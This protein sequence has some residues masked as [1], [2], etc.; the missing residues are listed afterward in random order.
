MKHI[1][2]TGGSGGVGSKISI[3]LL[4]K[5]Y[6]ISIVGRNQKNY[7]KLIKD[8]KNTSNIQFLK[9]DI[10]KYNEV[11]DLF[12]LLF[13]VKYPLYGLINVAGVQL[14]IGNFY[15]NDINQWKKN[16]SINLLGTV[17]MCYEFINQESQLPIQRKI[18]N[19][20]GGGATFPRPNFSAYSVSKIGIVKFTEILAKELENIDINVI[21]PGALNTKMLDE[22]IDAGENAGEEY[23]ESLKRKITGGNSFEKTIDLCDFLLSSRSNKISGKLI[24]AIWDNFNNNE[25]I[26]RLKKD[27]NFCTLRRI[28]SKNFE[29]IV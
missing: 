27:S 7:S 10:S 14:P 1:V 4:Q 9:A 23:A 19:F 17:N 13:K 12:K 29:S 22:V 16:L 2:I 11:S 3:A 18:I 8:L 15:K 6:F 5:K 25:F 21:S 24:S 26:E 20:S 28:D